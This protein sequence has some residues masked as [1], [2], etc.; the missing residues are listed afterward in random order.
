MDSESVSES[1]KIYR[2]SNGIFCFVCVHCGNY[3]ENIDI[4]KN[5]IL[6]FLEHIESHFSGGLI[7]AVDETSVNEN[8]PTGCEGSLEFISIITDHLKVEQAAKRDDLS[9]ENWLDTTSRESMD[10]RKININ[11][12]YCSESFPNQLYLVLHSE[13][14]H[15]NQPIEG[16]QTNDIQCDRCFMEFDTHTKLEEHL[17]KHHTTEVAM[18]VKL[19]DSSFMDHSN[20]C[21]ECKVCRRPFKARH[22]LKRHLQR[23]TCKDEFCI[24]LQVGEFPF[25]CDICDHGFPYKFRLIHHMSQQHTGKE[26]RCRYCGQRYVL[27]TS[28]RK[29]ETNECSKRPNVKEDDTIRKGVNKKI[30]STNASQQKKTWGGYREPKNLQ[31]PKMFNC[32]F[33]EKVYDT[34]YKLK[35]VT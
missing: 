26:N 20:E 5:Q 15:P 21:L 31:G 1:G 10:T 8:K 27:E 23:S 11:C 13:I 18:D 17:I 12:S 4:R 29:H 22:L 14:H 2:N 28:L 30:M 9:T 3:F 25:Y 6:F 19:D 33:C 35:Q 16:I 24:P 34:H 7:I 32:E